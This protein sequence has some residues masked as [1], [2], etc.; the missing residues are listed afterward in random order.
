VKGYELVFQRLTPFLLTLLHGI[1]VII[2]ENN[3]PYNYKVKPR[4]TKGKKVNQRRGKDEI[5][6]D[7]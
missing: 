1:Y 5:R 4:F 2:L 7:L 6:R 3:S